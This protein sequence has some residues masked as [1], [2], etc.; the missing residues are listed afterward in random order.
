M[1][2]TCPLMSLVLAEEPN[3]KPI[4]CFKLE[5]FKETVRMY[6]FTMYI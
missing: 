4:Y 2:S 6:T 1:Y 5:V 3:T